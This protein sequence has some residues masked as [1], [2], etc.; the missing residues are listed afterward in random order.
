MA[1]ARF[2]ELE[3]RLKKLR[4][5]FLPKAFSPTGDYTDRALDL[6]RGYR[7]LVH[8]EIEAF[9]EERAQEIANATVK[10]FHTDRRP[11]QVLLNLLSFHLVQDKVSLQRLKEIHGTK[12]PYCDDRLGAAQTAYNHV[13]ATN[14]G[15]RE[16]NLLQ[17][18]LPLGVESS[19]IDPGWLSTLDTFG[20]NRG[21]VAHKSIKAHQQINP[22]DELSTTQI[23]L[24]G[25]K[26]LDDELSKLR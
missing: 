18:L 12:K 25:L 10:S 13:L 16:Y 5:R 11:R 19:K 26:D 6:A 4:T 9:L 20:I 2:R 3:R 7:L 8:A 1:T 22:Q 14:N 21:E 17:I 24:K 15:I 23:L